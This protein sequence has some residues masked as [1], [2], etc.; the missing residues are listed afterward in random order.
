M[1][2]VILKQTENDAVGDLVLDKWFE[3]VKT[4]DVINFSTDCQFNYLR[5]MHKRGII[6]IDQVE[7]FDGTVCIVKTD[8]RLNQ[9]PDCLC[10][11]DKLLD[12]IIWNDE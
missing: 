4:N 6:E 11:S 2:T 5:V 12:K 3:S 8:G 7:C 9:W 1:K 10:T